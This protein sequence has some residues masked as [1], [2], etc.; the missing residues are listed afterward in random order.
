[1]RE[2]MLEKRKKIIL[3]I[4]NDK[5]YIPMKAK[6]LAILLQVSKEER[7]DLD[8]VLQQLVASGQVMVSKRVIK[9]TLLH[10][11]VFLPFT[12]VYSIPKLI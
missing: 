11:S 9:K 7:A 6:E 4:I 12:L 8:Y 3:D 2:E 1:M 10:K 5:N